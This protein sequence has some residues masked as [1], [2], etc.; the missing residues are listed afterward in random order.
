MNRKT[1]DKL[2]S[3]L[4]LALAGLLVVAGFLAYTGY[5]FANTTVTD[6]LTEQK[7][8]FPAA[9]YAP[10]AGEGGFTQADVDALAPFIVTQLTT[11]DGAKV[12]AEHYI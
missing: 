4:G 2:V 11:G 3:Y 7:I 5:S 8:S 10:V 1:L 6:Q 9:D 12:Y